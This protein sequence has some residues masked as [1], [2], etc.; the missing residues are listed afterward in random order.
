MRGVQLLVTIIG[1]LSK[2]MRDQIKEEMD[3][4]Q[5]LFFEP[6]LLNHLMVK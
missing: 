4:F 3:A 1:I 5:S 6:K 2:K